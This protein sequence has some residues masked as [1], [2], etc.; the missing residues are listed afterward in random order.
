MG[1]YDYAQRL[2]QVTT[3]GQCAKRSGYQNIPWSHPLG[4]TH[5]VGDEQEFSIDFLK[6]SHPYSIRN[7]CVKTERRDR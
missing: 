4:N 5:W 7:E 1:Q 2:R 3:P 6:R